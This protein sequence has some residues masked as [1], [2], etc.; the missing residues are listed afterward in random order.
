[1]PTHRALLAIL[2]L[3]L[4]SVACGL[5]DRSVDAPPSRHA[6]PEPRGLAGDFD[7]C[8]LLTTTEVSDALGEAVDVKPG[9]QTGACSYATTNSTQSK[10]VAVSAAQGSQA[11][12]LLQMSA[13]LG[14]L[15]GGNADS[16]RIADD[17]QAN[18]ASMSLQEVVEKA[19]TLLVPLGYAYSAAGT[20]D[21]PAIWAWNPMGAG[22]LQQVDGETYL[23]VSVIGLDE[24]AAK[25]L[26]TTLL[27]LAG[28]RLPAAF[29]I[30]LAESLRVEF[31]VQAPT[32]APEP[33]PTLVPP[34]LCPKPLQHSS[35]RYV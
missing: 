10:S 14:L 33:T 7:L 17:L 32:L 20:Q 21:R 26:T 3:L 12:D 6:F 30:E 23:A 5:Q 34:A 18:A 29:T 19:N 28:E 22:S 35:S 16:Q 4:G 31:T 13:S 9:L 1:M 11:R 8:T 24:P 25:S 2:G 15:F 27:A